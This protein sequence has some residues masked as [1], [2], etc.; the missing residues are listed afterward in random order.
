MSSCALRTLSS[1]ELGEEFFSLRFP[2]SSSSSRQP[3]H[4]PARHKSA[5][6]SGLFSVRAG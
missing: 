2:P 3:S 6:V 5:G 1:V 4:P